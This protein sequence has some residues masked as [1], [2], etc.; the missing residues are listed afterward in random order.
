[1]RIKCDGDNFVLMSCKGVKQFAC[2]CI[3][4]FSCGVEATSYNFIAALVKIYP[5]GTLNASA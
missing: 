2:V 3:P 5:N 1:M 4:K